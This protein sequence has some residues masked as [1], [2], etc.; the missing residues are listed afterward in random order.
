M[1]IN[2]VLKYLTNVIYL[3]PE[4][5]QL[6]IDHFEKEKGVKAMAIT[7]EN[8]QEVFKIMELCASLHHTAL[9]LVKIYA[10]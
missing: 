1:V 2:L 4:L 7:T 6:W 5:T 10:L 3:I 9:I 8:P